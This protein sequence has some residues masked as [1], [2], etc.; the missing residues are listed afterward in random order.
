MSSVY[1]ITRTTNVTQLVHAPVGQVRALPVHKQPRH[2]KQDCHTEHDHNNDNGN[3]AG[4]R[5]SMTHVWRV[6]SRAL[7]NLDTGKALCRLAGTV[8]EAVQ[9]E[10]KIGSV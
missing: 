10:R 7:S 5:A 9:H 2:A 3:V 4:A 8:A 1:V 6:V